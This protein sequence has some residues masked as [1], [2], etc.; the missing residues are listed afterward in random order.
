MLGTTRANIAGERLERISLVDVVSL[1]FSRTTCCM[2]IQPMTWKIQGEIHLSDGSMSWHRWTVCEGW[3]GH[4]AGSGLLAVSG[5]ES[6]CGD[7][8]IVWPLSPKKPYLAGGAGLY[9]LSQ[10]TFSRCVC[11]QQV[12]WFTHLFYPFWCLF[13]CWVSWSVRLRCDF[14]AVNLFSSK[15]SLVASVM[16]AGN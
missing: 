9:F 3:V 16:R 14:E 11:C 2:S 1:S 6:D 5:S 12:W 8:A 13:C 7:T 4:P 15:F 10:G